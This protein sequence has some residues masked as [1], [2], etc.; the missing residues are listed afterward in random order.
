ME[1]NNVY[2]PDID[3]RS[4]DEEGKQNREPDEGSW[5]RDKGN[6]NIY[7]PIVLLKTY[8]SVHYSF[9]DNDLIFKD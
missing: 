9:L 2:L 8:T 6:A 3:H 7:T 5:Q 1:T 4:L